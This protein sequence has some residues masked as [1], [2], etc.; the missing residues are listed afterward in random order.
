MEASLLDL[1]D[2]MPVVAR[3][4]DGEILYWSEGCRELYGYTAA[5][6]L[7][8]NAH[9]LLRTVFPEPLEAIEAAL[10]ERGEWSGRLRQ[11]TK[12]GRDICTESVFRLRQTEDGRKLVIEQATDITARVELEQRSELLTR[13]LEHRVKNILAVV[14]SLARMTFSN[15]PPEQRRKME[16]RLFALAEANELLRRGAWRQA[17]FGQVIAETTHRLGIEERV[18]A[19]GPASAVPA[20]EAMALTLTLHELATNALKYGALSHPNGH[21][22]LSWT[23]D[24]D[25]P[26]L[27]AIRWRER[28]GPP[29]VAPDKEGFGARLI[30]HALALGGRSSA[31]IDY[32]PDGLVCEL[33]VAA[34]EPA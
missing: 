33:R 26:R 31:R 25:D 8:R 14:Q 12:S 3:R 21:V 10:A 24:P 22:E 7:G 1:V 19:N 13:E 29:V 18:R 16:E 5:E 2:H 30:R 28:D 27:L 32:A 15:A 6:A 11:T 9:E 20:D 17:D 34:A 23:R 4:P